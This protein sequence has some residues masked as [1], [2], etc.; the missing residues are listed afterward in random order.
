MNISARIL[1][2]LTPPGIM[3]IFIDIKNFFIHS[4]DRAIPD[5]QASLSPQYSVSSQPLPARKP[6]TAIKNRGAGRVTSD[7]RRAV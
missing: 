3:E 5:P 2:E 7:A 6:A 4:D 1:P